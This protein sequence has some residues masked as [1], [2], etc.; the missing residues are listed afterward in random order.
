MEKLFTFEIT[1]EYGDNNSEV[2]YAKSISEKEVIE[3][4][5]NEI[6]LEDIK[7]I[8]ARLIGEQNG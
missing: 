3:K 6:K 7:T 4:V 1:I 5:N 2:F 8:K